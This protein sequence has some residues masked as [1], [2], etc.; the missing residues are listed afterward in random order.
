M[1]AF[2]EILPQFGSNKFKQKA[3]VANDGVVAQNG[4]TGLLQVINT[5]GNQARQKQNPKKTGLPYSQLQ[6]REHP[7][8]HHSKKRNEAH[9]HS[10]INPI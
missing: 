4:V 5:Q 9:R 10:L 8:R 3:Q 2:D 7:E 6:S 1:I